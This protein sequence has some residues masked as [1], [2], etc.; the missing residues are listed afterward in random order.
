M[1]TGGTEAYDKLPIHFITTLQCVKDVIIFSDMEMH[2]GQYHLHDAL[3]TIAESVKKDN[4]DF[5][6][7]AKLKEAERLREDPLPLKG[8][9][10]GWNLDKYKFLPMM[11][12]TWEYRQDA[13]WYIFVEAD[14]GMNWDNIRSFLDKL[15]SR[16]SL[17]IGSPTYLDIEFAH[18]GTGYIISGTAMR[19]AV[20]GHP[21]IQ[22]KYDSTV[23]PICCGDRMIAKVLLDEQIKLTR[24]WP[25]L[26]GE[27]PFTVPYS[28]SHWC[29]PI[30]TMHHMTSLEVSQVWNFQQARK[31]QGNH[32][33]TQTI[34]LFHLPNQLQEPLL[35]KDIYYHFV[36]NTLEP[37][38]EDWSNLSGDMT[39]TPD[40]E[41]DFHGLKWDE[42]TDIERSSVESPGNCKKLC[43][44]DDSCVQW[45][46]HDK[47]CKT[48]R[49][50]KL[51]G[52]KQGEDNS[53]YISGWRLDKIAEFREKMGNC[54]SGPAW[55]WSH[56]D[57]W[58]A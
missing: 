32:V 57:N 39:Y 13:K 56:P 5:E 36:H 30:L 49:S 3:D 2:M 12:K 16:K 35:W 58:F 50:V 44:S 15:D 37:I 45:E 14:T 54:T 7:Y 17:Y 24:A 4:G 23:K 10:S 27:K 25:M 26:N 52:T 51:G 20:G 40:P 55:K 11:K 33:R 47:E 53:R 1:K 46:H 22:E 28:D 29:A 9:H 19:K 38:K 41:R 34:S 48:S 6:L 21:D 8:K 18:G 43:D 42:L 31:A